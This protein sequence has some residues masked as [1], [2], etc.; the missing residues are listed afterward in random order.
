MN[1]SIY[2]LSDFH[3]GVPT[4]EASR[5]REAEVV[6]FLESIR[7]NCKELFLMGDIFDFWF[8]YRKV[9]PKGFVR[10]LGKLAQMSDEGIKIWF[11]KGNHDMWVFDYLTQEIGVEIISDEMEMQ[12][13]GKSF[14]LHHGDGLG[15]GDFK[16]KYLRK[17]FR[18]P[19]AQWLF[20]RIHPNL[21]MSIANAWSR[22]SRAVKAGKESFLG[23]EQEWLAQYAKDL[24]KHK[25]YDYFVFGHRHLALE[26]PLTADST[27]VNTGDWLHAKS[28][29]VFDGETLK[30]Q[31][32]KP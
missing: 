2:F 32:Y 7:P 15:P 12:R 27:Y 18:S 21:G 19:L 17:V 9:V 16:Y 25:H 26:I 6:A 10:L 22:N 30:L 8:E 13:N 5:A 20:A 31:Y 29:A 14:Y 3:L 28:Y 11:F 23:A 1:K 4:Y 24:L